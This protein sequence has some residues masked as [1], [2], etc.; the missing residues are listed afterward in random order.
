M[1][2]VGDASS[3][4]GKPSTCA[5]SLVG[6]GHERGT[7]CQF[8]SHSP[9][10]RG[11]AS[12]RP[13]KERGRGEGRPAAIA[14]HPGPLPTGERGHIRQ[15]RA[16][17]RPRFGGGSCHSRESGNP[18]PQR[19]SCPRK[20]EHPQ[21]Q[22]WMPACAGM[23]KPSPGGGF[24]L[25][26]KSTE[27]RRRFKPTRRAGRGQSGLRISSFKDPGAQQADHR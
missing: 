27:M 2:G 5:L 19:P 11:C 24:A 16:S 20:R 14:P 17:D 15:A 23:T 26:V 7:N 12:P 13:G 21:V 8:V 22:P 18:S 4:G 1:A 3:P 9:W 10:R 25:G 6:S